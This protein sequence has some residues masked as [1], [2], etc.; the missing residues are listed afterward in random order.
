MPRGA[1]RLGVVIYSSAGKKNSLVYMYFE[2]CVC[3]YACMLDVRCKMNEKPELQGLSFPLLRGYRI[4][5]M[6]RTEKVSFFS[7]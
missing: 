6:F 3:V 4:S 7:F 1:P 5:G 2:L